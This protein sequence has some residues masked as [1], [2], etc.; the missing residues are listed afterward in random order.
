MI[1]IFVKLFNLEINLD[2]VEASG[3]CLT[4]MESQL[5]NP[6]KLA[7]DEAARHDSQVLLAGI[8]PTISKTELELEYMTQSP[9]YWALNNVVKEL[10]GSDFELH[11]LGVDELSIQPSDFGRLGFG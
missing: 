8:L 10:K 2:P 11:I 6:L 9:R 7:H 3:S 5:K 4:Q 1:I